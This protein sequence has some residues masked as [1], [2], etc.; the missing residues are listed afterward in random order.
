[1]TA[2]SSIMMWISLPAIIL[3]VVLLLLFIHILE[4]IASDDPE[5]R[6]TSAVFYVFPDLGDRPDALLGA[7]AMYPAF[8]ENGRG[9][10]GDK[11]TDDGVIKHDGVEIIASND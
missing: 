10:I 1:M 8:G 11:V 7:H 4:I 5:N 2:S 6:S 3:R 9:L